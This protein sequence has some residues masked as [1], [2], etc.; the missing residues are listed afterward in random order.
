MRRGAIML[1][2]LVLAL[3]ACRDRPSFDERYADTANAIDDR[4][5]DIDA[6]LNQ[7]EVDNATR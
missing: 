5:R 7:A 2:A 3:G 6:D 1:L 4:A